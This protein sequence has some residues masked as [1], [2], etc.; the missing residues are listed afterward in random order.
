LFSDWFDQQR[1]KE[2]GEYQT[3]T[4]FILENAVSE[5]V[6]GQDYVLG[7]TSV[8]RRLADI[9]MGFRGKLPDVRSLEWT[10]IR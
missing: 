3:L 6:N 10:T 8:T 4:S 1:G 9:D 5:G 7:N 2:F